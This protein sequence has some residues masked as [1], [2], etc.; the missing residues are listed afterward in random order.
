M[1]FKKNLLKRLN[2]THFF[3]AIIFVLLLFL[4]SNFNS[5][6]QNHFIDTNSEI[7][8]I[9]Y[10]Y[11]DITKKDEMSFTI[12]N[13]NTGTLLLLETY[14]QEDYTPYLF[15]DGNLMEPSLPFGVDDKDNSGFIFF[16]MTPDLSGKEAVFVNKAPIENLES[17]TEL[18]VIGTLENILMIYAFKSFLNIIFSTV[19]FILCITIFIIFYI[20]RLDDYKCVHVFAVLSLMLSIHLLVD[21]PFFALILRNIFDFFHGY[22]LFGF[23]L[24]SIMLMI[25]IYNIIVSLL[26]KTIIKIFIAVTSVLTL[27][28]ILG[29]YFDEN[30]IS[31]FMET[32]NKIMVLFTFY[33]IIILINNYIKNKH[34]DI[35]FSTITTFAYAITS[36]ILVN[37]RLDA[38]LTTDG[39]KYFLIISFYILC[40]C[41]YIATIFINRR[42]DI[43]KLEDDLNAERTAL[44][45]LHLSGLNELT[46]TDI[47]WLCIKIG[48]QTLQ[49]LSSYNYCFIAY[50]PVNSKPVT[51]FTRGKANY[52]SSDIYS[53]IKNNFTHTK[54]YTYKDI[55]KDNFAYI[56]FTAK[57]GDSLYIYIDYKKTFTDSEK[58]IA[59]ILCASILST[60]NNS[61]VYGEISAT[62]RDML[63]TMGNIINS[64][65]SSACN[66]ELTGELVFIL[67]KS[68]GMN[69]SDANSLR[70]ASYIHNIGTIGLS[71]KLASS[72]NP[73][74]LNSGEY[75]EHTVIGYEMLS[76]LDGLTMEMAAICSL[77]HHERY[78]GTGYRSM[79]KN[80][81]SHYSRIVSI[82]SGFNKYYVTHMDK[83][84]P[85][86][87][88]S[89]SFMYL[90]T[91]KQSKY[92][93][94]LVDLFIKQKADIVKILENFLN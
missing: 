43:N 52:S 62:E 41:L 86:E 66:C 45:N 15:I 46:N 68:Y 88:L 91:N 70:L 13:I 40:V 84:D 10:T 14:S 1:H 16:D 59:K 30:S 94:Y 31:F 44:S 87:I 90:S 9:N 37:K 17:T 85:M 34:L 67:A 76:K 11:N 64:R 12:P 26:H 39:S 58:I 6:E 21:S 56:T 50:E 78:D 32:H 19:L 92:D 63:L 29:Y 35:L 73:Y 71:D 65:L 4:L 93:P 7:I 47:S 36:T 5:Y 51:S 38:S 54:P 69:E 77:E 25:L 20:T 42:L 74:V 49:L 81:T 33:A 8:E 23:I 24:A 3:M 89:E 80:E 82:V 75:L 18:V 28:A 55:F 57:N 72:S 79:S 61:R 22:T 60:F 27:M 53:I 2:T 48:S 83:K